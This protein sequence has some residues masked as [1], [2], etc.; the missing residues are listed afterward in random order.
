MTSIENNDNGMCADP[1]VQHQGQTTN[2]KMP[3]SNES[4]NMSSSSSLTSHTHTHLCSRPHPVSHDRGAESGERHRFARVSAYLT[5]NHMYEAQ[6]GDLLLHTAPHQY[7]VETTLP[8][9]P[10]AHFFGISNTWQARR[11]MASKDRKSTL[12]DFFAY[13]ISQ[14]VS[15]PPFSPQ[16]LSLSS[17]SL[18]GGENPGS[19]LCL[20]EKALGFAI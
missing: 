12:Y 4:S 8:H 15:F 7:M 10:I 17:S 20:I 6:Q 1:E 11:R 2:M 18:G 9:L 3:K 13:P 14:D 16:K 5:N 19:I